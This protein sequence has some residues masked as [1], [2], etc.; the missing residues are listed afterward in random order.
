MTLRDEPN[1]L[2]AQDW[3]ARFLDQNADLV[4]FIQSTS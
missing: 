4:T 3:V 1:A 2:D